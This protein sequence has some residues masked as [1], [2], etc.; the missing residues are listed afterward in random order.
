MSFGRPASFTNFQVLPPERGSFPL[1]HFGDCTTQMRAYMACLKENKNNNGACRHLSKAYLKC[2]MDNQ[3][4]E[5]ESMENLGFG[6]LEPP[7]EPAPEQAK[8]RLL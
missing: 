1:D 5:V 2:R 6:D 8:D 7:K 4:M 3:L